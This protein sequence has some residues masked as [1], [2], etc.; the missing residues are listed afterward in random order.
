MSAL[1]ELAGGSVRGLEL[2][3]ARRDERQVEL[4]Q[5]E[6]YARDPFGW[7]DDHVWIASFLPSEGYDRQQVRN[8]KMRLFPDQQQTIRG[9][10]DLDHL[11]LTGQLRFF[12][13]LVIEKSRQIGETWLFAAVIAWLVHHHPVAGL[14]M[15][16]D[17]AEID[18]GG[19]ANTPKS[20]FGKVRYIDQ[21]LPRDRLA[22]LAGPL[23]FK[24][25]PSKI[26]NPSNGAVVYGEGQGDDPGR[27]QSLD[28]AVVDEAARVQHGE[29]VHASLSSA[30]PTGKAYLSTPRGSTNMHA[31]LADQKPLGWTYLRLHWSGHPVYG[32]GAHVAG[33]LEGCSMCDGVRDGVRWDPSNPRAHR[34][35]GKLT[36]PW[37]DQEVLEKT[38]EQV[39]A[40]LDI[41]RHG[42]LPGRVFTE[43]DPAV[44]VVADG[45]EIVMSEAG[46][47]L[48]PVELAWDYGLDT[49]S[50][51]VI[52]NAVDEVRIVGLLEMGSQHN[53]SGVPEHVAAE[54]RLY[55]MQL[56][57]SAV[58]TKPDVTRHLRCVG[59]PSG[60]D[61]SLTTG[62]PI[63]SQYR[64]QGFN[65]GRPPGRLRTVKVTIDCVK[66]L[67]VGS[68]KPLRVCGVNAAEFATHLASNRWRSS[69][70]GEVRYG[71][72]MDLED[73]VH[74]HAC[75]AFA[76][77]AVATFPPP[78]ERTHGWPSPD[79]P[80]PEQ[81]PLTRRRQLARA[82]FS[83]DD[84]MAPL[85]GG[86]L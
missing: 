79:A 55:L 34:Y 38:D 14:C 81:H 56:G 43:F 7:I 51:V 2:R 64:M 13:N 11:A 21:R 84:E 3:R 39:A 33:E 66:R 41:D 71:K 16:V 8:V 9:W 23:T 49:T 58:E 65:I 29:L 17:L 35:R 46:S 78:D 40:E 85:S 4:T 50:V 27:G 77:W 32:L 37:Y 10:I 30:C 19:A 28:F 26:E 52:Q 12:S 72:G 62:R 44:H 48:T 31:R 60:H 67:L 54:L 1:E 25:K 61:R 63:V 76:Y 22:Y 5:A 20:L 82:A 6:T 75:R 36:S 42:S 57:L 45:I 86:V 70:T 74:N 69:A 59:D 15:H 83:G 18:D 47:P 53:M 68:P 80:D 24:Q 73:D